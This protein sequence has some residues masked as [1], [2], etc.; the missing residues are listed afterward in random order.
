MPNSKYLAL[1]RLFED[2]DPKEI[3]TDLNISYATV[4]RY[5]RELRLAQDEGKVNSLLAKEQGVLE[6]MAQAAVC[7]LPAELVEGELEEAKSL[8][9]GV[10]GL[11]RLEEDLQH[12]AH[13]INTRIRIMVGTAEGVGEV[14]E[15]TEALCKLQNAFFGKGTQ[16]LVQQNNNAGGESYGQ[17]LNDIPGT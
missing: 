8:V 4:L 16:V 10:L 6:N 9:K 13:D 3:S 11:K 2:E 12:T 1:V 5:K 17:F 7:D 14:V 15:L